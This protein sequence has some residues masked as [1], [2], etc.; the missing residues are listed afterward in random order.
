M[1]FRLARPLTEAEL[2]I[3]TLRQTAQQEAWREIGPEGTE[4]ACMGRD[5]LV[6]PGV[7]PPR[8]DSAF[9]IENLSLEPGD[10]VLDVG[11]G[12]GVLAIFAADKGAGRVVALDLNPD[13]VANATENAARHGVS[14]IIETRVSDV[15]GGLGAD[16]RFDLIIA[17]LPGRDKEAPDVAAAA[18]WDSGFETH[19]AF[20]AGARRHLKPGGRIFMCKANYPEVAAMLRLAEAAGFAVGVAGEKAM[21][22]GD[23]R[24]YTVFLFTLG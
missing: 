19:K 3:V 14:A 23:P 22:G 5:F 16:E 13:A 15:F 18:Q 21:S 1:T 6:L 4:V 20:F 17:N 10:Q 8:G 12:S 2:K 9:L 11:T 7:F 24:V